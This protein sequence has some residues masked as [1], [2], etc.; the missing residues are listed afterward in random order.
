MM[1]Q[2]TKPTSFEV[3]VLTLD[4]KRIKRKRKSPANFRLN[5]VLVK[6]ESYDEVLNVVGESI[7]DFNIVN[8]GT[9]LYRLA[10]VSGNMSPVTRDTLRMD[11]RFSELIHE[12]VETLEIDSQAE[13]FDKVLRF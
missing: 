12:I 9:A 3:P 10:L 2:V 6:A 8:I 7:T 13:S 1:E 5:K 11:G 4:Q